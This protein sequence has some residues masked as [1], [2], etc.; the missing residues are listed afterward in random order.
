MT[1]EKKMLTSAHQPLT[2]AVSVPGG[3]ARQYRVQAQVGPD[4]AWRLVASYAH[5]EQAERSIGELEAA[6]YF[7]RIVCY[8]CPTAG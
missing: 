1:R 4:L 2:V 8:Q 6:G 3:I 5:R 7:A